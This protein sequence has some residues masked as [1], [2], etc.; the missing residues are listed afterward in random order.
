M[1][2]YAKEEKR[3]CLVMVGEEYAKKLL[4]RVL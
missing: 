3:C 4:Y 2:D 1:E